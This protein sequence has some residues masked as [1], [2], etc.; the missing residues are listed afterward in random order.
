M[1]QVSILHAPSEQVAPA[2]GRLQ[3]W[4]HAPQLLTSSWMLVWQPAPGS[5]LQLAS[6][7][8]QVLTRQVE[9]TQIEEPPARL[10]S[11]LQAPQWSASLVRLTSQPLVGSPS[12]SE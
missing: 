2:L 8:L 5:V 12:Q 1:L 10:H 11:L 7:S 4:P 3:T 6:P 9:F